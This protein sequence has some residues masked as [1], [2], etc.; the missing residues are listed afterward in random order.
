MTNMV[1]DLLKNDT[2]ITSVISKAESKST[3]KQAGLDDLMKALTGP[4][5]IIA[6]VLIVFFV[7]FRQGNKDSGGRPARD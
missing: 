7:V 5:I 4:L 1:V 6:I 2:K 3:S